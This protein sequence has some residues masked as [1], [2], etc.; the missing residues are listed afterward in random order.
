MKRD[1]KTVCPYCGVGCGIIAT[2]DGSR[3]LKVRGDP[4]HPANFGKLCPKGASVA[5]TV[6]V[7][8]RLRYPMLRAGKELSIVSTETAIEHVARELNRILQ[9]HGPGAIG[10]YTSGQLTT[11]AQYLTG[12]FA[13]GYLR[14]N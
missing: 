9:Q 12:K 5:Q 2:T 6:H 10:F 14:T 8:S 1:V 7:T 4:N 3:M 13:R 11:E